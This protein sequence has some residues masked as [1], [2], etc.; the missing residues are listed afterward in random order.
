M[1]NPN[2]RA[3]SLLS[4]LPLVA[5]MASL[6][7]CDKEP[8]KGSSP[9][10][11]ASAAASAAM[12]AAAASATAPAAPSASAAAAPVVPHDCP[13]GSTGEGSLAK[14]CEAKGAA[15]MME[16]QWTGKT[17]DKGP[18]FRVTSKST[19]TILHGKV[20]VYFYDKAGKQLDVQD[21]AETPP[22]AVPYRICSGKIFGGVMKPAEKAT[23]TFSCVTKAN[24][25]E[26]TAAIE[27]EM[28]SVG[29]A[30][31]ADEKKIDFY[32]K[33]ADLTPDARKKGGVK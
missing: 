14:P 32:W 13:K 23:I 12:A 29:F 17:D 30:D 3:I 21:T 16:V 27:A 6:T 20:F 4:F 31:A 28:Q 33:N 5:S 15:R 11:S 2:R 10:A 8:E 26:G 9:A 19:L 18:Q 25:P 24:I 7:A 22:K 1:S